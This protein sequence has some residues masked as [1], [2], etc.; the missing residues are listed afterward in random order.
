MTTKI[1]IW[2]GLLQIAVLVCGLT[3]P[4]MYANASC[5][6]PSLDAKLR[7]AFPG[8]HI[9]NLKD[10]RLDD[11]N[12]WVKQR[13]AYCPGFLQGHFE[14]ATRETYAITVFEESD[15]LRQMLLVANQNLGKYEIS[16]LN[17]PQKVAYLSV[18]SKVFPG[19][20]SNTDGEK[21][22]LSREA[23]SYEAIEAGS[24]LY[25]FQNG[26]YKV[27]TVSE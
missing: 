19:E 11:R 22:K 14:S 1:G 20:Y 16:V 5:T 27:E 8:W 25:Y 24:L 6:R 7:N 21:F 10:L 13:A 4:S 17:G 15:G 18:I 2:R 3:I 9:V 23:I 26:K 12:I